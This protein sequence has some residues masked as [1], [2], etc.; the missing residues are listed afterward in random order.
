MLGESQSEVPVPD[1]S[2][3]ASTRENRKNATTASRR[4]VVCRLLVSVIKGTQQT[5]IAARGWSM[6]PTIQSGD[7][8]TVEPLQA[9]EARI[10]DIVICDWD[11]ILVVHR[12]IRYRKN[13]LFA[14]T[15][16]D[17]YLDPEPPQAANSVVGRVVRIRRLH[18]PSGKALQPCGPLAAVAFVEISLAL[19]RVRCLP[20]INYLSVRIAE[21]LAT[22]S[23]RLLARLTVRWVSMSSFSDLG[24]NPGVN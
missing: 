18:G 1:G 6:C 4:S 24:A 9:G 19:C 11:N 23:V 3:Q 22:R 14:Q 5:Q 13:G 10:G 2:S 21:A 17:A 15:K 20:A 8:L 12:L 7:L 16:G